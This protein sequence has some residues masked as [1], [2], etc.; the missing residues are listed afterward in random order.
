MKMG[1]VFGYNGVMS[2]R[3]PSNP[4]LQRKVSISEISARG[5]SSSYSRNLFIE[6]FD[7][8]Q[9]GSFSLQLGTFKPTRTNESLI[10]YFAATVA[11]RGSSN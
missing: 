11:T 4:Q 7:L 10:T 6:P 5:I 3:M 9:V 2:A 1:I 8:V